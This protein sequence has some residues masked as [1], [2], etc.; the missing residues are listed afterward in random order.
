M[1]QV[2]SNDAIIDY[3]DEGLGDPA[4]LLLPG[5]CGTRAAFDPVRRAAAARAAACSRSTGAA[6]APPAR[7][8]ATSARRTS[9]TTPSP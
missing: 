5:W 3:D 6:T 2:R 7:R 8:R 4:L 9:C 1:P